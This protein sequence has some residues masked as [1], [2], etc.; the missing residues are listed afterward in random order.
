MGKFYIYN[1]VLDDK[2]SRD[3]TIIF[4]PNSEYSFDSL[5]RELEMF[6]STF[7]QTGAL[8]FIHCSTTPNIETLVVGNL[9]SILKSIPTVEEGFLRKNIFYISYDQ[10]GFKIANGVLFIKRNLKEIINQGLANIFI[11]NGGLV[12]SS[13]ISHHFVFPSGKHSTKFLRAANVL[14]KKSEIDFIGLTTLHLFKESNF[15]NIYCD[16]LSITVIGYSMANFLKRFGMDKEIYVESFKSY[17][18]IYDNRQKFYDNSIFLIS[19][20]T[21][22]GLINYLK[23]QHPEINSNQISTLFYLP[24]DKH[25]PAVF[26]R[27]V[28]NLG[29]NSKL[30]YG[31]KSYETFKPPI[32]PCKYCNNYSTAIQILGDSFSLDEPIINLRNINAKK[33]ITIDIKEFVDSFRFKAKIGTALKVSYSDPSIKRKTYA[34]YIDYEKVIDN[35]NEYKT[36]KDK[37][38]AYIKQYIPAATKYIVYLNDLGSEKLATYIHKKVQKDSRH[39][40]L[41]INQAD[42]SEGQIDKNQ[43]GAIVIVGSCI[44]NGKNL[45]YLNRFFRNYEHFRLVYFV[46]ITRISDSTRHSDLKGN[47]KYG[48]YGANNASFIEVETL[49]CDNANSETPWEVEVEH[50]KAVQQSL[51]KPSKFISERIRTINSFSSMELKGGSNRIFY[52]NMDSQEL[53][54][55]KNSVFFNNNDYYGN[56]TQSDVYFTVSCVLNNMRSNMN[57]GLYQTNFVKN[58]LDPYLFNRFNDGIIQAAILR[59]AKSEELN[60]SF[61]VDHSNKMLMLL[62]TYI[63]HIE[64]YQGEAIF[65]FLHALAIGKL[66]LW[67]DHYLI[68]IEDLNKIKDS[69]VRIFAKC[70]KQFHKLSI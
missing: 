2:I 59:S 11:K 18:G 26:E 17:S 29:V 27:V 49:Y 38:D 4:N 13:G 54:I 40:I 43:V 39:N 63:K 31:I 37:L 36:H 21:S 5:R 58:V 69:R 28:C 22:G 55:R 41:V 15:E 56:I 44:T 45:L 1:A 10:L 34:T 14:V 8:I 65:E 3:A 25:S 48:L 61:S 53:E 66:R 33:Y 24:L 20:S 67:K 12:E 30:N 64:E 60:Y 62:Q 35:I 51:N 19:A 23:E 9:D 70:I 52:P 7:H 42:L 50:L 6:F 46:G 32:R 47:I 57:D 68:L 16:T